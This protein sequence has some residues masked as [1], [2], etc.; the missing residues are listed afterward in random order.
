MVKLL[1]ISLLLV[2]LFNPND[3][4][5]HQ[6][7]KA[8]VSEEVNKIYETCILF[9]RQASYTQNNNEIFRSYFGTF[10]NLSN[11]A[12]L[13]ELKAESGDHAFQ[14]IWS[15]VLRFAYSHDL[16]WRDKAPL[17]LE[18]QLHYEQDF[19]V[20]E[21][22]KGGFMAATEAIIESFLSPYT[23]KSDSEKRLMQGYAK[24][25]IENN[26]P[27]AMDL[28]VRINATSSHEEVES[29]F[30]DQLA[31]Y[32]ILPVKTIHHLAR[33][34]VVGRYWSEEG[35]FEFQ[36]D[37]NKAK[38]L[39]LFLTNEKKDA[40]STYQFALLEGAANKNSAL[41]YFK[42]AAKYGFAKA[43][44]WLGDYYSCTGDNELARQFLIRSKKLGYVFAD[45]SLGEIDTYGRPN[46]CDN[47]WVKAM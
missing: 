25:L 29:I 43:V 8:I 27:G 7:G 16:E 11:E 40:K 21:S 9:A 45:D 34:L 13:L 31:Q 20:R 36:K 38:E 3:A 47:G 44:G 23:T 35:S 28:L 24:L 15:Q 10:E 26:L 42:L 41:K 6:C 18:E 1:Q 17:I 39:Y 37:I 32:K 2:L 30:N 46:T 22:A 12:N 19:W 14:F 5:S 4:F 33:S